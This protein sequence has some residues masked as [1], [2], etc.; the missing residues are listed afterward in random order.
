MDYLVFCA[1]FDAVKNGTQTPI[2]VYDF[3]SWAVI[4]ALS[5]QSIAQ[6]SAP[7]SIPDFTGGMWTHREPFVRS[8]YCLEEVC[9]EQF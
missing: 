6:G 4:T 9:E 2:D 8:K 7:V 5:E 3:A 1:F